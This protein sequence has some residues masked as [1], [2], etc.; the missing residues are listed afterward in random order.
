MT[1]N[2]QLSNVPG[3]LDFP[4][5]NHQTGDIAAGLVVILDASNA[6]TSSN[7]IDDI[8]V[9]LPSSDGVGAVVGV[10]MEILRGTT[11]TGGPDGVGRVRTGGIAV[12]T[13]SG[14]ITAGACVMAEGTSGKVKTQ[15]S[16]KVQVG[17]AL[18]GAGDGDPV[19]VLLSSANN[20]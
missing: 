17:W 9:V 12:C 3:A 16:A 7:V 19:A 15:T 8:P 1:W 2:I 18:T 10:T 14:S 13:A 5:G 4:F 20:A 11:Y 6:M